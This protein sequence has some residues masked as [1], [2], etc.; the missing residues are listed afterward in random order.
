MMR[1]LLSLAVTAVLALLVLAAGGLLLLNRALERGD[2]TARIDAALEAALGRPVSLGAIALHPGLAP[3]IDIAGARI[4]NLPGGSRPDLAS[5][6]SLSLRLALAPLL[7]GRVEIAALTL[8]GADI[9]L[10]R[11]RDGVPNWVLGG[12]GGGEGGTSLAVARI[13]IRDARIAI[14]AAWPR[15]VEIRA[16]T[17]RRAGE[18]TEAAGDIALAGQAFSVAATLAAWDGAAPPALTASLTAPG[19]RLDARGTVPRSAAETGWSLALGA[20]VQAPAALLG[21]LAPGTTM[22]LGALSGTATLGPKGLAGIMLRSGPT[23]IAGF[24]VSEAVLRAPGLDAASALTAKATRGG[25]PV[26]LAATLPALP[27]LFGGT[28]P[29]VDATLSAAGATLALKGRVD[30]NAALDARLDAPR[31][32]AIGPLL[33]GDLPTLRDLRVTARATFVPPATLRLEGLSAEAHAFAGVT[34]TLE[35][36]WAPRLAFTGQLAARR[37]DLGAFDDAPPRRHDPRRVIP[38]VALPVQ[39][40]RGMDANLALSLA[41][42]R[43]AG[44]DWQ[45]VETRLALANGHLALRPFAATIPGG[46]I[47][48]D[49]GLDAAATPPAVTLALRSEGAG[50]DLP[51]LGRA[52]GFGGAVLAG[53]AEIMLDLSGRGAT[54]R[55]VAATLSGE[56]GLAMVRGSLA[57]A[58]MMRVGPDLTRALLPG[59]APQQDG[60]LRCVALRLSAESGLVQSRALLVEGGFGRITGSLALNL[61]EETIAARLLPDLT[62]LG[63]LTVRAPVT[64]GGTFAAPR[65]GVEP[66][67][68]LA[69]VIGDTVANRLWRSSTVEWLRGAAGGP[70]PEGSCE[71]DLPLARLGRSGPAPAPAAVPVP[72]VPRELQGA[73]GGVLGGVARGTETVVGGV[74]QGAGAVVG[75]VAQGAGDVLRGIG[76][77]VGGAGGLLRPNRR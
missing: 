74:A 27:A 54:L 31:F 41:S 65:V 43:A 76:G 37:L 69:Q 6:E 71:A 14:P 47:A 19:M 25:L 55:R 12:G 58:Q 70:P 48:G 10:E 56:A 7:S 32:A 4:A 72:L 24:A 75:G 21:W 39:A 22:P 46:R 73:A 66:G 11:D 13:E 2:F 57:W 38:D 68:A 26:T 20:A 1:R 15:R 33:G 5:I 64:I 18:G 67:Q 45:A 60:A 16:L 51:A 30:A 77:V 53:P 40:L 3:R 17:L 34:G 8:A 52:M 63:G 23:T 35:I 36:G 44:I 28:A 49:L 29:V 59:G 61:R 50:I 9:L 42:M 62:F